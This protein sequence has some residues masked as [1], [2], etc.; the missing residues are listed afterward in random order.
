MANRARSS[1]ERDM[2]TN[3]AR[4]WEALAADRE[5]H[6]ARQ[7]RLAALER[8]TG[9]KEKSAGSI[10]IDQLNAANDE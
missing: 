1:G 7:K 4:T 3:M 2:L 9:D 5:A 6:I 8:Q 10:P